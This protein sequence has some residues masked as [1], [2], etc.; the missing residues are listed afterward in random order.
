[1]G[2]SDAWGLNPQKFR[3]EVRSLGVPDYQTLMLPLLEAL[4]DGR[5]QSM[6]DI[7]LL[8]SRRFKLTEEDLRKELPSGQQTVFGNRVGWARTYLKKAGL[9]GSPS[10]GM[11]R[12]SSSGKNLLAKRPP[13]IDN[14]LLMQFDSFREFRTKAKLEESTPVRSTGAAVTQAEGETPVETLEAAYSM[15]EAYLADELL[16]RIKAAPPRVFRAPR[17]EASCENGIWRVARGRRKGRW[18]FR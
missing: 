9:L 10:R 6:G 3:F 8:L 18:S 4:E 1:M 7:T 16:Q 13:R 2:F 11:V 17:C 15:L 12:I 14:S 5:A